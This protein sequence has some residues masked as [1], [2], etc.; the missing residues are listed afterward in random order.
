MANDKKFVVKNGLQTQNISFVDSDSNNTITVNQLTTDTLSF[1][2]DTGQLFSITDSQSGTI[3]AVND[4]SGVP[5]IEVDDTGDIRFAES[6]GNVS[7]GTANNATKLYVDGD[8]TFTSGLYANGT[9]GTAGQGLVSNGSAVYW[10]DNPGYTGSQ[11]VIGYTGSKGDT[12]AQGPIGYTGSKGDIGYTGSRGA[13][14]FT[15]SKGDTGAQGETGFTGSQGIQ[16]IQGYTGS[17][18]DQG[19]QG[20]TGSKGDQ[21]VI[22]YTGSKGDQGVIG[23]TGSKGDQGVIGYTGSQ[24]P[25]GYTGSKGDQGVIGYTGSK[26]DQGVIGYT[27]SQGPIGYTGSKGDQG[28]IGYTGSKG[29]Q[30]VIGYTGSRGA[31]GFTGSKGDQGDIGYTGSTGYPFGGGTFT[32]SVTFNDNVQAQFGTGNDLKIYHDGTNSYI[33]DV[34]T[35]RIIIKG[36]DDIR[37]RSAT[38]EEMLVAVADAAVTLYYDN[39]P[40]FATSSVGATVTGALTVTGDLT[41]QGSTTTL[42]T[43]TLQVEDKNIVINYGAGDTSGSADGAG[44]TIQ[45]A[46]NSTT[47]ATILWDGTNDEFDFSHHISVPSGNSTNWNTAFSWGDHSTQNYAYTTGDTFTGNVNFNDSVKAQFGAGADLQIYHD[48]AHSFIQDVGTGSLYLDSSGL[49]ARNASNNANM[50]VASGGGS[51]AL[52]HNNAKKIET[53][54]TG[55]EVFNSIE[56]TDAVGGANTIKIEMLSTDTLSFSGD[57]GELFSITDDLTGTIFSVNDISGIPSIEVDATGDI[58]FAEFSGNVSIGTANNATALYVDGDVTFTSGLYANGTLGTAGQGLVSNGSAVYWADN[59]GYTGSQGVIGYTGSQGV[60]GYTGSKGDQGVIGYT[61]SRGVTGFTGSKGDQG[62]IGYTGSKGDQGV[63]GY[64]GSKGDQGVIGYTGSKGDQGVIGYTGSKGD[65]GIQGYT[66]SQGPIGYTGSKGDTGSQGPIG[67]TGSKGDT[68]AQGPIGYTGS[69]GVIGYTGSKGDTGAQGP[70]GYTGSRG[71]TGFTGSKGDT[72]SQGPIGYTGSQGVIGY[73]GS[74]G[75]TGFTGSKGDIGYT[76]ST[77]YPFG[78]GTF[79]GSVTFNDNVKAQ[80]GTSNDLQIYHDGSN[81]FIQ[82]AGTGDFI[83]RASNTLYLQSYTGAENYLTAATNGAVNL[84]YDNSAKLATASTGVDV[85]GDLDVTGALTATTKSFL[86]DHPSKEGYKLRYG[87]LEGPEN[88]VY[89]RGK[90][91]ESTVIDLPYYWADLVHEDTITVSLT[92]IG[93]HNEVWVD[94]IENNKV[95]V[96]MSSS[97]DCFYHV[98]AERKDIDKLEV[99]YEG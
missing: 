77:G 68:G 90:L 16:G 83:I 42:E 19:I 57:A 59:P 29:D 96:G 47:D 46:V 43:A 8:V 11:G 54:S 98:F 53:T 71:A 92:P 75:A 26:G 18:G 66:G 45:D 36:S 67:Y 6:F 37:L 28:V 61:G 4:I 52:Y 49:I 76:G 63:I 20:Y 78:G 23:Y 99:E 40:K 5:S 21:G 97:S 88:G 3:F 95:Y 86:I 72:G 91:T 9:L 25:I 32:G 65:Q 62:V 93:Q 13:T 87:S 38:N 84:Y 73:T 31:T 69:R 30:G 10:A 17:K 39:S 81:S 14:G 33:D 74:R 80:F 55:I 1:S 64:T 58:R 85:T 70:I 15:G 41:V 50:I 22:G 60:I 24:G 94:K 27:G 34:G 51:V 12:G 82:D 7:I 44:I 79:T 89:V 2:G 56:M 35:G 48:G